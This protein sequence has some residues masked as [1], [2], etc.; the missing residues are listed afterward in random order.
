MRLS[1]PRIPPAT[2]PS[3]LTDEAR[4]LLGEHRSARR[5]TSSAR[6]STTRSC[7]SAGSCSATTSCSSRAS[8]PAS[9]SC[10]SCAPAGDAGPSTSGDSISSSVA[11]RASPTRRS[12]AD[13]RA[14][15]ARLGSVRRDAAARGRR[16]PRRS[17]RRRRDV[18]G[19]GRALLH[20]AAHGPRLRGRSVHARVH[21]A[22]LVR[23]AAGSGRAG[24]SGMRL[25]G[26]VAIVAGAGQTPGDTI[27]NGRAT[28]ILFAREGARVLLV[29]R[30]LESAA[31]TQ[32]MIT[33]EGGDGDRLRSRRHAR[34]RLPC[35]CGRL[36]R[37]VRT[38]RRASQQRRDRG[39]GQRGHAP[40]AGVLAADHRREP[41]RDVPHLQTRPAR[42]A[43]AAVRRDREHLLPG[44]GRCDRDGRV[45]GV[46]GRGER[47]HAA[48]RDR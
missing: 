47:A 11:P 45:Q 43:G 20:A 17:H 36:R 3:M 28:A 14:R 33:A 46:E 19:A 1:A 40:R 22:E 27:G 31:E 2:D 18:E 41:H 21:G 23:G 8:R 32:E 25:E 42:D 9:G 10:S 24:V 7:S 38:D 39:G 12:T 48:D 35:A 15:R 30:R 34:G 37:G 26:K 6:S 44:L 4:E 5:S 13:A 16:T 29:D